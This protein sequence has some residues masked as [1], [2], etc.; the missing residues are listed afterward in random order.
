MR[1][2]PLRKCANIVNSNAKSPIV[3]SNAKSPILPRRTSNVDLIHAY[4]RYVAM[5]ATLGSKAYLLTFMFN[6]LPGNTSS[7]VSQM[8]NEVERVYST[9]VPWIVRKP[10]SERWV[11]L[12]PKF[13]GC[14]DRPV[15]KHEKQPLR[16]VTVNDGRHYHGIILI[17]PLSRLQVPLDEH[18]QRYS[19]LY[20]KDHSKLRNIDVQ[21]IESNPGYTTGYAMK[22][23]KNWEFT[24]DHILILPRTLSELGPK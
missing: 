11:S 1:K 20:L 2:N 8:Q 19:T 13:I 9:L 6:H 7:I 5:H 23:L 18:F 15:W 10:R 4:S 16:N 3:N 17:H 14:P 12:L 21:P 24:S 22:G